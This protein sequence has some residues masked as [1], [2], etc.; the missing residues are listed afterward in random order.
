MSPV[1]LTS[2]V[3]AT[4]CVLL[5]AFVAN[6]ETDGDWRERQWVDMDTGQLVGTDR[7]NSN[8]R[9]AMQI[10]V[11]ATCSESPSRRALS[12]HFVRLSI[13]VDSQ[14]KQCNADIMT[15]REMLTPVERSAARVVWLS[16]G[17]PSSA[18][19]EVLTHRLQVT[20]N[21]ELA[22]AMRLTGQPSQAD[23]WEYRFDTFY[24]SK[25]EFNS[26]A[27]A[28]SPS[29]VSWH[30]PFPAVCRPTGVAI[31]PF[32]TRRGALLPW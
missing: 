12:C 11:N 18:T 21:P 27:V 1:R 19:G 26:T 24:P 6:A 22:D 9:D 7:L 29:K 30:T 3:L 28:T 4:V 8:P 14:T 10:V 31:Q 32:T 16:T 25:S 13:D 17:K 23:R 5:P 15:Y 20:F 2:L